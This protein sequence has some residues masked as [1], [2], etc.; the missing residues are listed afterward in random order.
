MVLP[1]YERTHRSYSGTQRKGI[2]D[3]HPLASNVDDH[4]RAALRAPFFL[5]QRTPLPAST[6]KAIAFLGAS[7]RQAVSDFWQSQLAALEGLNVQLKS[8]FDSWQMSHPKEL[9]LLKPIN[10]VLLSLLM[11]KFGLN[12]QKWVKQLIHGFPITGTLSQKYS[13]PVDSRVPNAS[14][15][16]KEL[17]QS[18]HT[19]FAE[20]SRG[21]GSSNALE[22]WEGA[23]EQ[24][25][26]GWLYEPIPIIEGVLFRNGMEV[27][28]IRLSVSRWIRPLKTGPSMTSATRSLIEHVR[29][30]RQ[31][32]WFRGITFRKSRIG[33]PN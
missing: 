25:Q 28:L 11:K 18:A 30:S 14:I 24:V 3:E 17:F 13:C 4:A 16:H 2:R 21:A 1:L 32:S 20:R 23:P 12:G 9:S 29:R 6:T 31:L 27:R 10:T 26:K 7:G 33:F 8:T 15:T 19:R 5:A 22:L